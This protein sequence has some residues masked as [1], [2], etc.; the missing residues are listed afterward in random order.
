MRIRS[1]STAM[2]GVL[3]TAALGASLTAA[4]ADTPATPLTERQLQAASLQ[5]ADVPRSFSDD[6]Q[7]ESSYSQPGHTARFEM[8]VDKDGHKV[9]GRRPLQRENATVALS[10]TGSGENITAARVVSTDIYGYRSADAARS[11]WKQL[12]QDRSRCEPDLVKNLPFQGVA[13]DIHVEQTIKQL[14]R[15]RGSRGWSLEQDVS[16]EIGAGT[17]AQQIAI[18]VDGYTVYRRHGTTITRA[19]FANYDQESLASVTLTP[20]W[21]SFTRQ[22]ARVMVNRIAALPGQ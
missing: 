14:G 21:R 3:A 2:V 13:I 22:Q 19:Q 4:T 6:P 5:L 10:Q 12:K 9:F 20:Q 17:N 1:S 16:T 8:C 15:H 7:Y 11:A 18:F